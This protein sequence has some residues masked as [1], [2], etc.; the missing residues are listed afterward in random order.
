MDVSH[1]QQANPTADTTELITDTTKL[2]IEF[3]EEKI[4]KMLEK[5]HQG[6]MDYIPEVY[7][8]LGLK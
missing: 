1:E 4:L 8:K 3:H 7:L 5:L 2:D 6:L